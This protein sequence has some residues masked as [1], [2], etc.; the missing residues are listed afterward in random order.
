MSGRKCRIPS[1]NAVSSEWI[2]KTNNQSLTFKENDTSS[3]ILELDIPDK[4]LDTE[5][6]AYLADAEEE[7]DGDGE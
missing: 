5:A 1:K 4:W 7:E 3:N 6:L 2:Q